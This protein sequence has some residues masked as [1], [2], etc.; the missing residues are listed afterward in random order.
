M[1][2][3]QLR[4]ERLLLRRA[5]ADDLEAIHAILSNV[6]AMRYWSTLPHLTRAESLAWLETMIASPATESED[7]IV[8][9]DGRVVGKAGF[10]RLPALG[11]ILHP[12][13]WGRGL[14]YEATRAIIDHVFSTRSL[15]TLT[16]DVDPRNTSSMAL[17]ARL[18]FVRTGAAERTFHI[19]G[20]WADSI[21]YALKRPTGSTGR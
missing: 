12:E 13:F 9:L 1:T 2:A 20:E 11:Y 7:F 18:G 8:E 14:A 19:G 5:R 15:E 21:Y 17:L 10:F 4:T 16:A 3:I 6:E